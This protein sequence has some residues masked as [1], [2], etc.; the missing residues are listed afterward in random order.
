MACCTMDHIVSEL[1]SIMIDTCI[2]ITFIK[3]LSNI[4]VRL[5]KQ[6][7]VSEIESIMII[8]DTSN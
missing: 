4:I 6:E 5:I 7:H 2:N 1:N 8:L 3:A